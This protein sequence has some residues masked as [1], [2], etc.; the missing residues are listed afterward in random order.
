MIYVA[1][2]CAI[3]LIHPQAT[4]LERFYIPSAL[5]ALRGQP[6]LIYSAW[7]Q[8]GYPLANGPLSVAPLLLALGVAQRLGW[9]SSL[10]LTRMVVVAVYS[11]FSLLFAHEAV[12]AID[13]Y[14]ARPAPGARRL[15]LYE[16]FVVSLQLWQSMLYYG[17]VEQPLMLWLALLAIRQAQAERPARAGALLGLALLTRTTALA[18]IIPVALLLARAGWRPLWR[19]GAALAGVVALGLAPFALADGRDLLYSLVTFHNTEAAAGGNLWTLVIGTPLAALPQR[20]DGVITV[21]A[22]ALVSAAVVVARPSLRITSRDAYGLIA[23]A[24]LCHPAFINIL[25]PYYFLE[26]LTFA[27]IWWLGAALGQQA[28]EKRGRVGAWAWGALPLALTLMA[29]TRQHALALEAAGAPVN[30]PGPLLWNLLTCGA[31]VATM[32]ALGRGLTRCQR[33]DG[34]AAPQAARAL[35]LQHGPVASPREDARRD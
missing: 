32:V 1:L 5:V 17:H 33:A 18:I 31:L 6:L 12:R 16:V 29:Q 10:A 9:L 30:A 22:I 4:D 13:R 35:A 3:S 24:C 19:M 8:T 14:A 15:L 21:A 27:T 11:V 20:F 28:T 26:A 23:L 25:W 7:R 2:W 34:G